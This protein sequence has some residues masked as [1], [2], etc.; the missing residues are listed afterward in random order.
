MTFG[1]QFLAG[2]GDVVAKW[3]AHSNDAD[4][5]IDLAGNLQWPSGA[6]VM[7]ILDENGRLVRWQPKPVSQ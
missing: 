3:D 4:G 6:V 7:Q 1:V 2:S 5:A